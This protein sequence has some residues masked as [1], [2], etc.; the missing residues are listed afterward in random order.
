MIK[1]FDYD[2]YKQIRYVFVCVKKMVFGEKFQICFGNEKKLILVCKKI[3]SIFKNLKKMV[4]T[5]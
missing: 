2:L 3:I 4:L 1:K 5:L